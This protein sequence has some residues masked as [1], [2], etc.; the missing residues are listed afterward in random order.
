M[1]SGDPA[2]GWPPGRSRRTWAWAVFGAV[3]VGLVIAAFTV[4]ISRYFIYLP[5]PIKNVESRVT[6]H[7]AKTYPSKG[8]LALTTV[9][10]ESRPTFANLVAAWFDSHQTVIDAGTLTQ[11]ASLQQ[12]ARL[13]RAEMT[14]SKRNAIRTALDH[15]GYPRAHGRGARVVR[16]LDNTPAAGKLQPGDVVTRLDGRPIHTTCDVS[17]EMAPKKPGAVVRLRVQ[18]GHSERSV[19]IRTADNPDSPGHAFIGIGMVTYR[20]SYHPGIRVDVDTGGI[21]GPSAGT[22][23]ALTIYD[24]LTPGDLTAGRRIAG[25]GTIDPCSG[26]VGP[27][28]GIQEKVAAAESQGIQ[29]FLAPA[30][31]ARA[32]RRADPGGMKIVS[33]GSFDQALHYLRSLRG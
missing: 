12:L 18:R 15:L 6:I 25:T 28:G 32:A 1:E 2:R 10:V 31:D 23:M 27:I 17:S 9:S 20:F 8:E 30:A 22:M 7:G 5:G 19:R 3:V 24:R 26:E 29:I 11:G 14:E 4:P 33:I 13:Q 21:G 16:V